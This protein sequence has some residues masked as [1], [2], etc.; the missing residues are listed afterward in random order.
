MSENIGE[1][2][3]RILHVI[4][5]L[6]ETSGQYNEHCLP[7]ARVRDLSICTYFAPKL[8]PPPEIR[9]FAGDGTLRGFFRAFSAALEGSDY[10]VIH[11][12]APQTATLVPLA[13]ALSPRRRRHWRSLVYTVQDSFHDYRLRN[14]LLMLPGLALF[15]R[16][17][18]CGHAAYGSYPPLWRRLA[19]NRSRIVQNGADLDRVDR[20]IRDVDPA[21]EGAAFAVVSVGRLEKVKDPLTLVAAFQQLGDQEARLAILGAGSMEARLAGAIRSSGLEDRIELTG[22]VPRDEVFRRCARADLY[23]SCSLGEGLPVS[24]IEAMASRCPVVLSDIPPHREL[25]EGADFVPFVRLG[26]VAGFAREIERFRAMSAEERAE[27]GGKCRELVRDRFGLPTMHAALE[28]VYREL[29]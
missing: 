14:R 2:P 24:V 27:I 12:H 8:T 11:V 18:F 6:G 26:D 28:K 7:L 20:A 25:A 19:G 29:V 13:V 4:L 5:H 21:R 16:V 22:L 9:V 10:D 15:R 23:V 3:L 1:H 17:V